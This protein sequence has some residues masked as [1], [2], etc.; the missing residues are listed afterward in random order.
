MPSRTSGAGVLRSRATNAARIAATATNEPSVRAETQPAS[1]R[2]D[3]RE[4]EQQHRRGHA[5]GAGDVERAR[6][7]QPAAVRRHEPEAGD[8]R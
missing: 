1:R 2:L 5:H 8:Q 3:E 7:A 6:R 4:D